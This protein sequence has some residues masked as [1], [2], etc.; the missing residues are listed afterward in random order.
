MQRIQDPAKRPAFAHRLNEGWLSVERSMYNSIDHFET[1][2]LQVFTGGWLEVCKY[3]WSQPIETIW[4]TERRC[5]LLHMSLTGAR[6]TAVVTNLRT[7]QSGELDSRAKIHLVPP[8]QTMRCT[9][10]QGQLRSLR[11]ML[12]A[13]LVES[14]LNTTPMWDWRRVPLRE[15]L[16]LS[17][18]QIEWLLRRMYREVTEPDFAT[19]SVIESLAKQLAVEI[20]R[21]FRPHCADRTCF[22]GGLSMRHKRLIR[23]RVYSPDPLPVREELADLCD[24]TVRHLSRAFRTETG[25]TLGRYIE[26]AMVQRAKALLVAGSPVREVAAAV[27]YATA[28]SFISAFRRATGTLPGDIKRES[29]TRR[30]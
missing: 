30:S 25:Q 22:V 9:S 29:R 13:S 3:G 28:S 16:Q 27:G 15:E 6:N 2:N 21:K 8:E 1:E 12:D 7:G 11:C 24:M 19:Q 17:G 14:F 4:T 23:D 18:G 10:Q 20:L 5:Y 26:S